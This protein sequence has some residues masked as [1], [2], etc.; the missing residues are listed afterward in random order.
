[1]CRE[2]RAH[3]LYMC[4]RTHFITHLELM[5]YKHRNNHRCTSLTEWYKLQP[6]SSERTQTCINTPTYTCVLKRN[7][8]THTHTHTY[9]DEIFQNGIVQTPHTVLRRHPGTSSW[10]C[11]KQRQHV[12]EQHRRVHHTTLC[13]TC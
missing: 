6:H 3:L 1:M 10:R 4:R 13:Y 5:S 7:T 9:T 2:I 8:N 12:K 11:Q